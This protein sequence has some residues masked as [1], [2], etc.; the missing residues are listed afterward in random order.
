MRKLPD[1]LQQDE[2]LAASSK[3]HQYLQMGLC[4]I[5]KYLIM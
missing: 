3:S 2:A 5:A 4:L 1:W